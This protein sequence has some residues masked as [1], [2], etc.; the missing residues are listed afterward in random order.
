MQAD[1]NCNSPIR[2]Q[3]RSEKKTIL[4][5]SPFADRARDAESLM[6]AFS[7]Q[8]HKV[9]SLS[10]ELGAGFQDAL[11]ERGISTFTFA[12]SGNRN[13]WYTLKHCLYFTRFCREHE[14]DIVYSYLDFPGL[15]S[16]IGQYFVRAR[17]I[18]C[19]HHSDMFGSRHLGF[20][21]TLTYYLAR[22]IIVVSETAR[23]FMV[24]HEK[25]D[26]KKISVINLAYDFK[27]YGKV[28]E[29]NARRLRTDIGG[30]LVLIIVGQL[31][32]IKRPSA[33]IQVLKN[34]INSGINAKL[35]VLGR[36]DLERDLIAFAIE[37]SVS[38]SVTFTGFVPNVLDYIS[39]SDI[40]LHPSIS[41]SS[42][43]VI[44]EASLL[45]TPVIVCKG[46]GDFDEFLVHN[47]NS[48]VLDKD[49]FVEESSE[50][51]LNNR[52]KPRFG[53]PESPKAKIMERFAIHN[54]VGNYDVFNNS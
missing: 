29:E 49:T 2:S 52:H 12:I 41:E 34:L 27:L 14:V 15:V 36:G 18:L 30:E 17:V 39:S 6:I 19:R 7:Q 21:Y 22:K 32:S 50:I 16:S 23:E 54:V 44:K 38:D 51:I 5:Y 20:A 11:A 13:W 45:D 1:G 4:F 40:L 47:K 46:V 33:A 25:I 9:L 42:C 53:L 26:E 43:V 48:F 3:E 31:I 28:N 8:G 35:F 10:Q 37:L 24:Q